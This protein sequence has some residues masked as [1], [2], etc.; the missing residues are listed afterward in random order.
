MRTFPDTSLVSAV[1][2]VEADFMSVEGTDRETVSSHED[3]AMGQ[4]QERLLGSYFL[5]DEAE[6]LVEED[7]EGEVIF[8]DDR[9]GLASVHST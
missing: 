2:S 5:T 3:E 8:S 9:F 7:E 4:D 6:T 1:P